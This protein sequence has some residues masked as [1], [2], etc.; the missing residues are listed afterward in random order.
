M[1]TAMLHE[2][3]ESGYARLDGARNFGAE[4]PMRLDY[5]LHELDGGED[6]P[7]AVLFCIRVTKDDGD[8]FEE[9]RVEDA[10]HDF[11]RAKCILQLLAD[12]L[13]TPCCLRETLEEINAAQYTA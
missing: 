4:R 12:N 9:S 1:I 7:D 5:Y 6:A 11:E 2:Q 8:L 10:T 3:R 13:V